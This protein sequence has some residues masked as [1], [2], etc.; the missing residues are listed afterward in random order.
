MTRTILAATILAIALGGTATAQQDNRARMRDRSAAVRE[1]MNSQKQAA[2]AVPTE[3]GTRSI[4]YNVNGQT[5]TRYF[6]T[7]VD[8][9]GAVRV[10]ET[11]GPDGKTAVTNQS[12]S[13][14]ED[15]S[16][17]LSST[18]TGPGGK[19]SS[20]ETEWI[21]NELGYTKTTTSTGPGGRTATGVTNRTRTEN[22]WDSNSVF[23]G[24]DGNQY[25]VDSNFTR[26]GDGT[27][28]R[29]R[30]GTG[31]NGQQVVSTDTWTKTENGYQRTRVTE[32]PNGGT[33]TATRDVTRD[34]N[35]VTIDQSRERTR[36]E[37]GTKPAAREGAA[38]K[39]EGAKGKADGAKKNKDGAKQKK[40]GTGGRNRKP[41]S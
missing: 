9:T 12:W 11:T 3:S 20:S 8:E 28:T 41:K 22:G 27:A 7:T 29:T 18:T 35:N 33:S 40:G 6:T 26:N 10:I 16:A 21:M 5:Y 1:Q 38:K 37:G 17:K 30:T 14:G 13:R 32:G 24:P 23:T 19:T 36:P 2:S 39:A 15:G 31:P 4:T 25:T 34:G